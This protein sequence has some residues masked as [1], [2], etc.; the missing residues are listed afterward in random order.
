MKR[1]T[2]CKPNM[3]TTFLPVGSEV[4]DIT[5]QTHDE[6]SV[7][8]RDFRGKKV[9]LFFYPK[10][11][12]PSCTKEACS[13]R[14]GYADLQNHGFEVLGVSPDNP[15]P[16]RNFI[17]KQSLPYTLLSDPENELTKAFGA[18]GEKKMR[19]KTY[20]GLLRSTFLIDEEGKV[21][22]VIPKVVTKDHANQI[23]EL[24]SV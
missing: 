13:L 17:E 21:S 11:S 22:H 8:L 23:I 9:V 12:S 24:L 5:V 19:G 14:D 16:L 1:F 4:P 6:Q 3:S 15:K 10:A 20:M 7:T 18:W 2:N